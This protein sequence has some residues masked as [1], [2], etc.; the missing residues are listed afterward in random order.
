VSPDGNI[1]TRR[2]W[3][4]SA[5]YEYPWSAT[6]RS[7]FVAGTANADAPTYLGAATFERSD[8]LAAN[9]LVR[10]SRYTTV[11]MEYVYGQRRN[12]G[13]ASRHNHELVVG[14]QLF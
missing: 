13:V 12:A 7:V 11:G 5:S 10:M 9:L 1:D 4:A 3:G 6:L 14:L 2:A 8:M